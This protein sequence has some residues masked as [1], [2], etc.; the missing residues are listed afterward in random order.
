MAPALAHPSA[1]P[2]TPA[3][4]VPREELILA[5]ANAWRLL[6]PLRQVQRVH[7]AALPS[8]RPALGRAP[9]I[10]TVGGVALPVAFAAALLGD[11]AVRLAAGHQLVELRAGDRRALL[12]VD[13]VEDLVP[14]APADPPPGPRGELVAGWSE[15]GS[16][17]AVLDVPA[18]L[19]RMVPDKG[20]P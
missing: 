10:L 1:G 4:L 12:W 15:Q 13:A 16:V 3:E 19:A 14:H 18:L 7:A 20:E 6:I 17:L 11:D 8:A 5:R 9:P 2:P